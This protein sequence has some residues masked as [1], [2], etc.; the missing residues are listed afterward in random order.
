MNAMLILIVAVVVLLLGYVFYGG[1]LARQWGIDPNR[2]TPA[3]EQEDGNDYVPAPPY[4]VLGHHFSS[5][6]GAGPINGPIQAAVFGWVPVLL[7]VLIG[8][9]FMGAVHDFGALF[10]S[11]RN[12][13]RTISIIIA[14]NVDDTAR[15]LF[16]IFSYVVLIL[17]VAAFSS[18]V[19]NTF[20]STAEK[21][22]VA[23]EQTA[24]VSLL[25]IVAAVIWGFTLHGRKLPTVINI[26]VSLMI[27]AA[28]VWLGFVWHP[29]QLSYTNWMIILAVY[30]LIASVT[31]VWI[32]LQPRDYLSSYLLYAL[33]LLA[34]FGVIGASVMGAASHLE[35]PAFGGFVTSNKVIVDGE[36]VI[37]KAAQ[38]GFLFPALFVTIACG[39]ISG[40]H[41][42]VASGTTSKQLDK[43]SQAQ[44]IGYGS[45][46]IECL[47][48][49]LSL[50]AVGFVW[51]KYQ[52]GG[53]ASP[54]AVFADGLSQM[55]ATIPG[56]ADAQ[57]IAY[58]LLILAVSVFCLT[59]LDTATRLARY[60]F[61]EFWIPDS[62]KEYPAWKKFLANKYVATVITVVFGVSLGMNGYTL[63]WPLFGAANQ[64]L[65]AVAL[66]AVC[67]WLGNAGKNNKMFYVPMIFMLAV[68]LTSLLLTALSKVAS[69]MENVNVFGSVLQLI[70]A[71]VLFGLAILLAIRGFV[72]I[73]FQKR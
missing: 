57:G 70:L 49:V 69:I 72:A 17:V 32:L 43:E 51:A 31:P 23:N 47:L 38:G 15:K 4:M 40:F 16:A 18:I 50:I 9:I 63:I 20:T 24:S 8:G 61:Q 26:G 44:A 67:I 60:L 71:L 27:I 66:L 37:N 35:I 22:N 14:E 73:A 58:A 33:M 41:S 25:F 65:A 42:M 12:K 56:L 5:I 39:A 46:L 59:S 11:L 3:H 30:I 52:A 1:Y 6:A 29:F 62:S 48:A 55:I 54:T 13:G 21:V 36:T 7:W 45:M 28:V 64:L 68:T 2:P 53:Y 34:I 10:A 19:A